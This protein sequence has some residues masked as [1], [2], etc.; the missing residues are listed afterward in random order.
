MVHG[1]AGGD[2]N[3]I[4]MKP[5]SPNKQAQLLNIL[6]DCVKISQDLHQGCGSQIRNYFSFVFTIRSFIRV[7][8]VL[9]VSCKLIADLVSL[10]FSLL[11]L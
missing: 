4:F 7:A 6:R 9:F 8:C 2:L 11:T 3:I 10:S 5:L 1:L